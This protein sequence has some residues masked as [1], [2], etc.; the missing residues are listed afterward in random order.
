[1]A[2]AGP[3]TSLSTATG[4]TAAWSTGWMSSCRPPITASTSWK[5]LG[6]SSAMVLECRLDTVSC[7]R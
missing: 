2:L 5:K 3:S 7:T 1:M 6:A 4:S